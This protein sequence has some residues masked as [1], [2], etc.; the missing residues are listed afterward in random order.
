MV[1]NT[2][3][4]ERPAARLLDDETAARVLQEM[5]KLDDVSERDINKITTARR[6]LSCREIAIAFRISTVLGVPDPFTL[7]P[8]YALAREMFD[9]AI[10]EVKEEGGSAE[11]AFSTCLLAEALCAGAE[12]D[13]DERESLLLSA[14]AAAWPIDHLDEMPDVYDAVQRRVAGKEPE[15]DRVGEMISLF[16]QLHALSPETAQSML[17]EMRKDVEQ[18]KAAQS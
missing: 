10:R 1:A 17:E 18:S 7:P 16:Q 6:G 9:A 12:L 13:D 11:G 15:P 3:A 8:L 14:L 5:F 2:E 4:T